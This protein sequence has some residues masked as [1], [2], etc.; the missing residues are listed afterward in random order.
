MRSRGEARDGGGGRGGDDDS[1]D[2]ADDDADEDAD[3]DGLGLGGRR[4]GGGRGRRL[5]RPR[6]E[7]LHR[8]VEV[9]D[10]SDGSSVASSSA[11]SSAGLIASAARLIALDAGPNERADVMRL[12][13]RSEEAAAVRSELD[14]ITD[15]ISLEIEAHG[16]EQA[17]GGAGVRGGALR[18]P[19][20]LG[21]GA[22]FEEGDRSG[23]EL[24]WDAVEQREHTMSCSPRSPRSA[25]AVARP[26][27]LLPAASQAGMA[28][29]RTLAQAAAPRL[30]SRSPPPLYV[31]TYHA[32]PPY[33]AP[34]LSHAPAPPSLARALEGGKAAEPPPPSSRSL[35]S[36]LGFRLPTVHQERVMGELQA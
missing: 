13:A 17:S 35:A 5:Q 15:E 8:S 14:E 22:V 2:D 27:P 11:A 33:R 9:T 24:R 6:R 10:P 4:V 19:P 3:D 1:D 12:A 36:M 31:P 30:L 32:P 20:S 23:R 34:H 28:A 29:G 21:L 7:I 25:R 16:T 26:K 18:M